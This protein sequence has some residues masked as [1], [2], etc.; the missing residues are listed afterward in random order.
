LRGER[1]RFKQLE[2]A[3][4]EGS[5]KT[6]IAQAGLGMFPAKKQHLNAIKNAG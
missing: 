2:I 5:A 6:A 3:V 1:G 4:G